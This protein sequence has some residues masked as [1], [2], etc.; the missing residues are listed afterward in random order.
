M[1]NGVIA[2]LGAVIGKS[3]EGVVVPE[4]FLVGGLEPAIADVDAF[5]V[6]DVAGSVVE[7]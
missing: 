5:G 3:F 1:D 6:F 7:S 4:A 2:R